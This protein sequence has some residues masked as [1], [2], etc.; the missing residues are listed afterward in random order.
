MRKVKLSVDRLEQERAVLLAR[1]WEE[2]IVFPTFLLPSR[3]REGDILTFSIEI[4]R[5]GSEKAKAEVRNLLKKLQ[6]RGICNG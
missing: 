2:E 6:K 1:G 4:D 3:V 5:P